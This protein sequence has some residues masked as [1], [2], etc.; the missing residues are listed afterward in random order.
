MKETIDFVIRDPRAAA[1]KI[2]TLRS[3]LKMMTELAEMQRKEIERLDQ[4]LHPQKYPDN[5]SAIEKVVKNH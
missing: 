2:I 1:K 5:H 3:S 4:L